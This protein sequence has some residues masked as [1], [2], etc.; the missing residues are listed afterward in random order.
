MVPLEIERYKARAAFQ[1]GHKKLSPGLER[2]LN[3]ESTN[4]SSRGL[5]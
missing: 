3:S 1:K 5:G 2:W 4:Y